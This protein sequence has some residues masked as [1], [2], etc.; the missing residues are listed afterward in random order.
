MV[1][2]KT[3]ATDMSPC[4]PCAKTA[5]LGWG[6][7]PTWNFSQH[8]VA[9]M[10]V[11]HCRKPQQPTTH[12]QPATAILQGSSKLSGGTEPVTAPAHLANSFRYFTLGKTAGPSERRELNE[13][14]PQLS[15]SRF[16]KQL[17]VVGCYNRCMV[18]FSS[19]EQTLAIMGA[20]QPGLA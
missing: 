4:F 20:S 12:H 13:A 19:H 16:F 18:E 14:A 9:A 1:T 7:A 10:S 11:C 5:R 8:R 2:S 3:E 17:V 6:H 15:L